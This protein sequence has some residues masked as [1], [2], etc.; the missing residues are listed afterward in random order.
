MS[1]PCLPSVYVYAQIPSSH[2]DTNHIV[3]G[4]TLK[5]S[6]SINHLCKDPSSKYNH[7]LMYLGFFGGGQG[8]FNFNSCHFHLY[9]ISFSIPLLSIYLCPWPKVGLFWEAYCSLV[10]LIQSATLGLLIG[11]FSLLAFKV[12]IDMY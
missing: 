9:E 1:S 8:S 5:T 7:I 4:P 3:L 12:L 6:F 2:K 10:F 11:A